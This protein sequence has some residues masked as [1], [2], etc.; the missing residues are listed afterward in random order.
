MTE[1]KLKTAA[2][3]AGVMVGAGAVIAGAMALSKKE[4]QEKVKV[5]VDKT[6]KIVGGYSKKI[7]KKVSVQRGK[8]KKAADIAI[9]ANELITKVAKKGAKKL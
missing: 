6:K 9:A 3:V 4:N 8:I 5:A 7:Q 2:K 1:N